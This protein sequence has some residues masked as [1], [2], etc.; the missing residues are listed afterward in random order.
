MD[1]EIVKQFMA[2][3]GQAKY[4]IKQISENYF[5]GNF[6][7]FTEMS[8]LPKDLRQKLSDNVD[9]MSVVEDELIDSARS[10]KAIL[11][12]NDELLIETVLM[13]HKSWNTVCVSTQVGCAMGCEFCATGKMGFKRNLKAQEIV[14]Q[15]IY[16]RQGKY[17]VSRVVF[18]GMGEPFLNWD[19][20]YKTVKT[21]HDDIGIGWRKISIST[22]GIIEGINKLAETGLEI[23]LAISLHS[24]KQEVRQTIIPSSVNY[25]LGDLFGAIRSYIAK[26]KRQVFFEYALMDGINDSQQDAADLVEFIGSNHLFYLN[27]INLN[28]IESSTI[29]PSSRDR[30]DKFLAVLDRYG[31]KYSRRMSLGGEIKAAC[32]QL[33]SK[34]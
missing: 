5:S 29:E 31:L 16:W 13:E 26:T 10:H 7:S 34:P 15:V 14:D 27:I 19:E 30:R 8:N 2:S 17:K 20:V 18:M 22:V 23:N 24:T 9:Y 3:Q 28:P 6:S 25:Q 12:L 32:G 4:R 11:K 1:I 33:I 21:I